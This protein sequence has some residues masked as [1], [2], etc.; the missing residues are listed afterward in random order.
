MT[1]SNNTNNKDEN[2]INTKK[3][4]KLWFPSGN[5]EEVIANV[6]KQVTLSIYKTLIDNF[7]NKH[8]PSHLFNEIITMS[9]ASIITLYVKL[10]PDDIRKD[11]YASILHHI[12]NNIHTRLNDLLLEIDKKE[13]KDQQ[14]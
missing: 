3:D 13:D 14:F 2:K 4:Y 10:F 12:T 11:M 6:S 7:E 1:Y 8:L 9:I 5:E